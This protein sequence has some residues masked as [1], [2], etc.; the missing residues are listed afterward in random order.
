MTKSK[1][2]TRKKE[3]QLLEARQE[4]L[5][6]A[7]N[8]SIRP[9]GKLWEMDV[10]SWYKPNIHVL[11]NTI[12]AFPF[13][14]IW[15]ANSSDIIEAIEEEETICSHLHAVLAFDNSKFVMDFPM[16]KGIK[17]VAGTN[18]VEHTLA[19]INGL[20]QKNTILLFSASDENWQ[21]EKLY[22][23]VFLTQHK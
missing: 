16:N 23:D 21:E 11:A 5:K 4:G 7:E 19:L 22:F 14:V 10:F 6:N 3:D 17:N 9:H 18:S 2:T 1:T 20:K 8:S 13:P 12:H 15:V